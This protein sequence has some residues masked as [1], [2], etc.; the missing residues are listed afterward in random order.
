LN[1]RQHPDGSS[2][3]PARAGRTGNGQSGAA[4]LLGNAM[5]QSNDPELRATVQRR[6]ADALARRPRRQRW[7]AENLTFDPAW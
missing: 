2:P 5:I 3:S 6:P 4:E 1:V 7:V